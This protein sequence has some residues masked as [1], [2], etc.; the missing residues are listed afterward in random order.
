MKPHPEFPDDDLGR[1]LRAQAEARAVP[2]PDFAST[3]RQARRRTTSTQAGRRWPVA[4]AAAAS[5]VLLGGGLAW[6]RKAPA[7]APDLAA[8]FAATHA[9]LARLPEDPAAARALPGWSSP[10]AGLLDLP[11]PPPR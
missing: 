6:L 5:V 11:S 7:P 2:P 4:V 1:L 8:T 3:L 9:A 10:T